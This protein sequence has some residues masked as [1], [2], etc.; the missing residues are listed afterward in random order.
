[1][2]RVRAMKRVKE[3]LHN[4]FSYIYKEERTQMNEL[5]LTYKMD[6]KTH[7]LQTSM[8]FEESWVDMLTFIS[9]TA[10]DVDS[11]EYLEVLKTINFINWS[12]KS[13]CGRMYID[14]YGDI[15]YSLRFTYLWIE[16]YPEVFIDEY[17][18]AIKYYEDLFAV[19]LD[20]A[21]GRKS[22]KEAIAFITEMWEL[23]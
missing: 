11:S 8:M 12:S 18:A 16:N 7:E 19:L 21:F 17:E 2:N 14:S 10:V 22:S 3:L 5:H 4:D 6:S 15:A 9:P 1:M 13:S 23:E 20:V